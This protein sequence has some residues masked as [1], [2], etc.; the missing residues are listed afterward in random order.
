MIPFESMTRE[1]LSLLAKTAGGIEAKDIVEIGARYGDSSIV[2]ARIASS[3]GG[4]LYCVECDPKQEW[5]ERMRV[6]GF[7]NWVM[8]KTFSPWVDYARLPTK[9]DY[10]LIDGDHRTSYCI[11]D[12]HFFSPFVRAGGMVAIHDTRLKEENVGKM[13]MRAVKIILEDHPNFRVHSECGGKFG[14]IVLRKI[15]ERLR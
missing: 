2:L 9:I 6:E 15:E 3:Y 12:F 11:A 7:D 1:E 10:L 5:V 13:V 8:L 14:M 4:T